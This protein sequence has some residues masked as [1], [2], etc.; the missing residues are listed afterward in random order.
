MQVLR[1]AS[2][3]LGES[4][5]IRELRDFIVGVSLLSEP[6][7]ITGPSGSG[8]GLSARKIHAVGRTARAPF[9][10]LGAG[11][12]TAEQLVGMLFTG[13]PEDGSG[14]LLWS[15]RGGTI[16]L[17]DFEELPAALLRELGKYLRVAPCAEEGLPRLIFGSRRSLEELQRSELVDDALL[18]QISTYSAW[19]PPLRDRVEDIPVLCSYQLWVHSTS[20]D[21]EQRWR[22][23]KEDVLPNLMSYPWP[24]NVS[25]L[26]GVIE[27]YCGG[28]DGPLLSSETTSQINPVEDPVAYLS[29]HLRRL[30]EELRD[31]LATELRT[32][33]SDL[34]LPGPARRE[35][36]FDHAS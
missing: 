26:N 10:K 21:Y 32:G 14:G 17:A 22:A 4:S 28:H 23:F 31:L 2:P 11:E 16:Y 30:H 34:L 1:K 13:N 15:R 27:R 18:E 36:F 5:A 7:L 12:Y 6:V 8:K 25:E 29:E 19:I 20:D 24:G 3:L 35:P 9:V 33:R